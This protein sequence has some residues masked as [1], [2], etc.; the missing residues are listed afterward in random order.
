MSS[1]TERKTFL[2]MEKGAVQ[3]NVRKTMSRLDSEIVD[4]DF[5]SFDTD[6]VTQAN[7]P[8][9]FVVDVKAFESTTDLIREWVNSEPLERAIIGV[10]KED[11]EESEIR[12]KMEDECDFV[13]KDTLAE[14]S[15]DSVARTI[16]YN[17]LRLSNLAS[18]VRRRTSA[19]GSIIAG[20]FEIMTL[21]EGR[22]LAT[23]LGLACPRQEMV[24]LGLQELIVNGVEHGNLEIDNATK[25]ELLISGEWLAEIE[26]RLQNPAF[27]D[28]RVRVS[29]RR[30]YDR[31]EFSIR[32]DGP[33]FDFTGF[34]ESCSM[35][36]ARFHGRGVMFARDFAFDDLIYEGCG[37]SVRAVVRLDQDEA[38]TESEEV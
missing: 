25:S 26:R 24:A 19:I 20:E 31:I 15:I 13:F 35:E 5:K 18:E 32:D 4:L 37:N 27:K 17:Q 30:Y 33:G 23:M 28:R 10:F 1:N 7:G 16:F 12:Q 21:D 8:A 29:F 34:L 22:N 36:H 11:E 9:I 2:M 38:E 3:D 14:Q 6:S